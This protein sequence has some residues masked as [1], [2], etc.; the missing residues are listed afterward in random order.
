MNLTLANSTRRSSFGAFL[1][2]STFAAF[3][4]AQHAYAQVAR[5]WD[6]GAGTSV[7]TATNNWNPDG[8]PASGD[9][10]QWNGSVS[11]NLS[12]TFSG[13]VGGSGSS[14]GLNFHLLSGQTSNLTLGGSA[15][16]VLRGGNIS[17][18]SGAGSF[19]INTARV[20][21]QR[22][23][24][25]FANNSANAVTLNATI[26]NTSNSTTR[27]LAF[28]GSGDWLV[29]GAILTT[30]TAQISLTKQGAGTLTLNGANTYAGSTSIEAGTLAG[31]G[32]IASATTVTGGNIAA[33]TDGTVGT[34][35]FNN[36]LDLSALTGK[37]KFDL[38]AT[39]SSDK[40]LLA[41]GSLT[42]VLNFDD[43]T[44]NALSGFGAGTYTLLD[45][46]TSITGTLGS[47]LTGTIGGLDGVLSISGQ[48]IIL[49]VTAIPEPSS[50]VSLA[51]ISALAFAARRNRRRGTT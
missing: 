42:G 3:A 50:Y 22:A 37:L 30:G 1:T 8:T 31:A 16:S 10:L 32:S 41:A 45:A 38:G 11:G 18:A 20:L 19:S 44:F 29:D 33:G 28:S 51:G 6:G 13:T 25:S 2:I 36:G 15:G 26:E 4:C 21:M 49:T 23:S 14:Q 46:S 43:F 34:L 40:I 27:S 39:D 9:T 5:I 12:L 47:E 35:T 48:D 24:H 7:L 17:V